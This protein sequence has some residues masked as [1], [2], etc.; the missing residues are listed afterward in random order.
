VRPVCHHLS[1]IFDGLDLSRALHCPVC[2]STAGDHARRHTQ[3]LLIIE[4]HAA[5]LLS[6]GPP[7]EPSD[8]TYAQFKERY[9]N[10]D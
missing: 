8:L 6:A 5:A 7:P 1:F 3:T 10:T 4:D 2:S 9:K